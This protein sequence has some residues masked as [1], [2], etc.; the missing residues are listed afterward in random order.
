MSWIKYRKIVKLSDSHD[1]KRRL[2]VLNKAQS[3][4]NSNSVQSFSD[5]DILDRKAIAGIIGE[6]EKAGTQLESYDWGWFGSMVGAGVFKNR[7]LENDKNLS[8]AL[9]HIPT[10]GDVS[11]DNY[12]AFIEDFQK[13]FK[14]SKRKGGVPTASRL[15]AMKR[16]DQFVCVDKLNRK[17]LSK[18][19]GFTASSLDFEMY[20]SEIIEP[21]MQSSWWQSPR[22]SG[23]DG[24]LWDARVAMLDAIYME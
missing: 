24:K 10:T 2:D 22:P 17:N 11:E 19:L 15:L 16:P 1:F 20:W 21:I 6:N 8:L 7:I 9:D 18:D 23:I 13:A 3:L 14:G 12:N 5:L 4:L